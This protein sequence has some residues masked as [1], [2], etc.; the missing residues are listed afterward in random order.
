M[1]FVKS[2]KSFS[3]I[4][5]RD[6]RENVGWKIRIIYYM[7]NKGKR[8]E[9]RSKRIVNKNRTVNLCFKKDLIKVDTKF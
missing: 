9:I 1:L 3:I 4:I 7:K 8:I 2:K 5:T 6:L